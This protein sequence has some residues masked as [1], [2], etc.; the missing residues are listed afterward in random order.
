MSNRGVEI[1]AE[2]PLSRIVAEHVAGAVLS[3]LPARLRGWWDSVPSDAIV[4]GTIEAGVASY[5]FLHM[6]LASMDAEINGI[7]M[8]GVTTLATTHGDAGVMA[9]GP[10]IMIALLLKPAT[11][12]LAVT[13]A[14]GYVRASTALI[15]QEVYS[16]VWLAAPERLI[17]S[18][19]RWLN[20]PRQ[21]SVRLFKDGN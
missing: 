20:P 13:A 10:M 19:Y 9:L 8:R 7:G 14:D 17:R 6:F 11:L 18:A 5:F 12:A 16:S 15:S 2:R 3:L 1:V 21:T 4:S